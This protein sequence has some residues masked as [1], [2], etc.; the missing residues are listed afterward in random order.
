MQTN[1]LLKNTT[2]VLL[3]TASFAFTGC[4]KKSDLEDIK[5]AQICLNNSAPGGAQACVAKLANNSSAQANQLKCAAYF[6]EEGYGTPAGLIT[7]IE[8]AKGTSC[9]GCSGSMNIISALSFST[10]AQSAAAFDVCNTSGVAVYSQLSSLVRIS[11]LAKIAGGL[12]SSSTPAQFEAALL[13]LAPA[14]LGTLVQTT[15][16]SSCSSSS[17]SGES[18]QEF[19]DELGATLAESTPADIGACLQYKLTGN[20]YPGLPCPAN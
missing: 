13:T 14:D 19:C 2:T 18:L 15:Y 5:N 11:T 3:I 8:A 6:I 9:T 20:N 17:G 1:N 12:T 10:D 4:D 7:A 16:A